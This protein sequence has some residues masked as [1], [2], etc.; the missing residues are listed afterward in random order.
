MELFTNEN[1]FKFAFYI[2]CI[3]NVKL[4]NEKKKALPHRY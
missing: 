4:K 1:T 2:V 3:S